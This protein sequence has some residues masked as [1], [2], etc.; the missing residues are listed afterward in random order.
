MDWLQQVTSFSKSEFHSVIQV[1]VVRK[2][3]SVSPLSLW[4]RARVRGFFPDPIKKGS[5]T[6]IPFFIPP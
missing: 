4:E 2:Y 3:N 5:L 1:G 6:A